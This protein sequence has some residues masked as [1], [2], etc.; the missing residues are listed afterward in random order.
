MAL[1]N[2]VQSAELYTTVCFHVDASTPTDP[3]S[4]ESLLKC[5]TG[6]RGSQQHSLVG[7]RITNSDILPGRMLTRINADSV[8]AFVFYSIVEIRRTSKTVIF[9]E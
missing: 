1:A 4:L 3:H 7:N 6:I 2:S 9:Q 5:T 8:F